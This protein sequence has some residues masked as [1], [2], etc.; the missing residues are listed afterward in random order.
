MSISVPVGG[1]RLR[2]G[3]KLTVNMKSYERSNHDLGHT[4]RTSLNF[5]TLVPIEKFIALP[6][7]TIDIKTAVMLRTLPTQAALFGS[8]KWQIDW[9]VCPMRLYIGAL[10]N[11]TLDVGTNMNKVVLP[12]IRLT[13]KPRTRTKDPFNQNDN[14]DIDNQQIAPDSLNKYLG[15]SGVGFNNKSTEI[16]REFMGMFH[17]AYYD[18]A[19][20]FYINKQEENAYVIGFEANAGGFDE[21]EGVILYDA[22]T[23]EQYETKNG[24]TFSGLSN[25]NLAI[26]ADTVLDT[27]AFN[28]EMVLAIR[29]SSTQSF[30]ELHIPQGQIVQGPSNDIGYDLSMFT[31]EYIAAKLPD[32]PHGNAG[33]IRIHN[34]SENSAILDIGN[35][36]YSY[37]NIAE[38]KEEGELQLVPFPITNLDRA[39]TQILKNSDIG[40]YVT[41]TG[42]DYGSANPT[43]IGY[44]P[45]SLN[46]AYNSRT[47]QMMCENSQVGLLIKT[48]LSDMFNNWVKTTWVEEA[49]RRSAI[50]I[51]NGS[52]T[53]DALIISKRVFNYLN[54]VM[55]SGGTMQDWQEASYGVDAQSFCESPMFIGG[56]SGDLIF[57]EVVSTSAA[58]GEPLGTL[59]G[60]GNIDNVKGGSVNIKIKEPSLIIGIMS[61]TPRVDYSQGNDWDTF[62][63]NTMEDLHKPEFDGI[64]FQDLPTEWLA[65]WDSLL[66]TNE[67]NQT[68]VTRFSLG[69]QP[70][71][72]QYMSNVNKVY[73]DFAR[74]NNAEF[75]VITRNYQ[76]KDTVL[77]QRPKTSIIADATTYVRPSNYN[78]LFAESQIKFQPIWAQIGIDI[79]A[80][81]K[82]SAA[83]MPML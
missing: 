72:V 54:R 81:R 17:L 19:K 71:W 66:E 28:Y 3:N 46:A 57:D 35:S 12:K 62:Q 56:M 70:A 29:N 43:N 25:L 51:S 37:L 63:L 55:L 79:S 34:E 53:M 22:N 48:H 45:Y 7:D 65:W 49:N 76:A 74:M 27:K 61:V 60:R 59:A 18:I 36:G 77:G 16:T 44:L 20:N 82:M 39:R 78:Y 9:F 68:E 15:I 41:I 52:F 4:V 10:H 1:K 31:F 14:F 69:K 11:N 24:G 40:A 8:C 21:S 67:N 13:A 23:G 26:Q 50:Q 58:E 6:G 75:M 64:G 80:R 2:S 33:Y 47:K 5:G 30:Y 73:G 83:I 32:E 42:D 38:K